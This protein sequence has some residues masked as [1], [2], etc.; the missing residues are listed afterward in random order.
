MHLRLRTSDFWMTFD[1][2]FFPKVNRVRW[3]CY[4]VYYL[5]PRVLI[6]TVRCMMITLEILKRF[7]SFFVISAWNRVQ[8]PCSGHQHLWSRSVVWGFCLQ[9]LHARLPR[10]P[11]GH[12]DLQGWRRGP[13]QLGTTLILHR[14]H[15]RVLSVPG[16]KVCSHNFRASR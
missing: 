2:N 5:Q 12:Q 15:H 7:V 4:C 9:D 11:L 10:C 8:I 14:R 1:I 3:L 16:S 6:G 13:P